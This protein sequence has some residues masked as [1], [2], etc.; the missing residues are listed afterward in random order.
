MP[1]L[2]LLSPRT[3]MHTLHPRSRSSCR[4]RESEICPVK[5]SLEYEKVFYCSEITHLFITS[6]EKVFSC[7]VRKGSNEKES[8]LSLPRQPG[9]ANHLKKSET[10]VSTRHLTSQLL[11]ISLISKFFLNILNIYHPYSIFH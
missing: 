9:H 3:T 6:L 4:V 5:G 2:A 1:F 7:H 8:A 10:A 11:I